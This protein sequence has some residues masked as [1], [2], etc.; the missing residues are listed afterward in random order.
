MSCKHCDDIKIK[1]E[2]FDYRGEGAPKS[3]H[4]EILDA[5]AEKV[6]P[7][8]RELNEW[9]REN[10]I[11]IVV[12]GARRGGGEVGT[13]LLSNANEERIEEILKSAYIQA[14]IQTIGGSPLG[15]LLKA[16]M[17]AQGTEEAP[18]GKL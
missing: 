5:F 9:L 8:I 12:V 18:D 16:M 4:E 15:I 11:G 13:A 2:R 3:K 10:D 17:K 1:T 7:I 14:K 6:M